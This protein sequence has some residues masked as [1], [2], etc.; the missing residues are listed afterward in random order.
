MQD[1]YG[2]TP[3]HAAVLAHRVDCLRMLLHKGA[4]KTLKDRT[5]ETPYSLA[6]RIGAPQVRGYSL[7]VYASYGSFRGIVLL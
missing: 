4:K 5:D 1:L 3:L 2:R 6:V 7:S